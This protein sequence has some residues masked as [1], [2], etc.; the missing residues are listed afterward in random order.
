[1][2]DTRLPLALCSLIVV[3]WT[4][5]LVPFALD[6]LSLSGILQAREHVDVGRFS[7]VPYLWLAIVPLSTV[8]QGNRKG[9]V[10]FSQSML[11][12]AAALGGV[13]VFLRHGSLPG[14]SFGAFGVAW[15]ACAYWLVPIVWLALLSREGMNAWTHEPRPSYETSS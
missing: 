6:A 10:R 15:A 4:F 11:G 7:W 1:M 3:A 5:M 8:R 2:N 13:D 14:Q 9:A 12:L